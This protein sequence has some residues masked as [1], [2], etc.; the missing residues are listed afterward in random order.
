[1]KVGDRE[2][3]ASDAPPERYAKPQ[4]FSVQLSVESAEEV[5]RIFSGLAEG[6]S[7]VMPVGKT[8]WSE[9]FGILVDRFG[10]PWMINCAPVS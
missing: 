5:D 9:R 2:I 10:I 4:G 7:V 3:M 1:M 6:G 8:F